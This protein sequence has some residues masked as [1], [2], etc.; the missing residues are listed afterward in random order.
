MGKKSIQK[1][2]YP[3]PTAHSG[4]ALRKKCWRIG[5]ISIHNPWLIIKDEDEQLRHCCKKCLEFKDKLKLSNVL[6]HKWSPSPVYQDTMKA[7]YI[8]YPIVKKEVGY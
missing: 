5:L 6:A 1:S 4:N 2:G 7:M 8:K 3:K